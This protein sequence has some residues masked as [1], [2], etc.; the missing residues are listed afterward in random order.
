MLISCAR[1]L[2]WSLGWRI[3]ISDFKIKAKSQAL[4]HNIITH[5]FALQKSGVTEPPCF[6][7]RMSSLGPNRS[8]LSSPLAMP[9]SFP[10]LVTVIWNEPL[11]PAVLHALLISPSPTTRLSQQW[12]LWPVLT[13][14]D[15][16]S[17]NRCR[18]AKGPAGGW[19][20][21]L[22]LLTVVSR[23]AFWKPFIPLPHALLCAGL[24][25]GSITH[26][27]PCALCYSAVVRSNVKH[28]GF[29]FN[30]EWIFKFLLLTTFWCH[31]VFPEAR[32]LWH[33]CHRVWP[34]GWGVCAAAQ[35][36]CP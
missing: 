17:F 21:H 23:L 3:K 28:L 25:P 7:S 19:T 22:Y 11:I 32:S 29:F 30:S 15:D 10:S 12:G 31:C 16:G 24:A 34:G 18:W 36:R 13:G 35:R 5:H 1:Q 2:H 14:R 26:L 27:L 20:A 4:H 33:F 8:C 9:E 6:S